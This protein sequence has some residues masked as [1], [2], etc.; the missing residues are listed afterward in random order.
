MDRADSNACAGSRDLESTKGRNT[1]RVA[2]TARR[3]YKIPRTAPPTMLVVQLPRKRIGTKKKKR[4]YR[5]R[6][7]LYPPP[8]DMNMELSR[9][10]L[11]YGFG[12]GVVDRALI[13]GEAPTPRAWGLRNWNLRCT[14]RARW[15]GGVLSIVRPGL[16]LLDGP[17]RSEPTDA[18]NL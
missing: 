14:H 9:K 15:V 6:L 5:E 4:L 12:G 13:D 11:D 2:K 17:V 1:E 8:I 16:C 7:K 3:Q 18:P 10:W